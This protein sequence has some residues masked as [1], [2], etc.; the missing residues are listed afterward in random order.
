MMAE[1]G[2]RAALGIIS[3]S[4]GGDP[5]GRL[6]HDHAAQRLDAPMSLTESRDLHALLAAL[7]LFAVSGVAGCGGAQRPVREQSALVEQR[8]EA[9][10]QNLVATRARFVALLERAKLDQEAHARGELPSPPVIDLLIISGGGDWGAF[11]AGFLRGWSSIPESNPLAMPRF[12]VVTGVSTGAL[13]AP[14]AYLGDEESL[15][16]IDRLYRNPKKDWV[17]QRWPLFFLPD[18]L[19]F[20]EVPGLEREMVENVTP[21]MAAQIAATAGEGRLLAVNTTDLDAATA[22]PF[23]L[24]SVAEQAAATGDMSR[25]HGIMLASAGI[26]GAFP[27]REIDGMMLVDGGV[28]GNII[29]G[30]RLG[31][32]DSLPAVWQ[33]LYPGEPIPK[34]RY[35]VLFNNQLRAQPRVVEPKWPAIVTRA[36][37]LSTRSATVTAMRHLHAMAEISRLKRGAQVEVRIVAIP[38][39]W[40][41]PVP[42]VFIKETMNHLADLGMTMGADP[43]SWSDRSP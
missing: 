23:D 17:R 34:I 4:L 10:Q 33:A 39:E 42:G 38:E 28:T 36:L 25:F 13:I 24:L 22:R 8:A 27:F 37:E 43:A 15:A 2:A 20:A 26:P 9:D 29:Y 35:W 16:R 32:E 14:F 5:R 1:A 6:A 3:R 30:G 12:D 18:N 7:A 40:T 41:P 11:G 21:A 31:E 19:S